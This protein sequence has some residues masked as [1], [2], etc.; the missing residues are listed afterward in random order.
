MT[1]WSLLES[2]IFVI[3][4]I[5]QISYLYDLWW[6]FLIW[7]LTLLSGYP[8]LIFTSLRFYNLLQYHRQIKNSKAYELEPETL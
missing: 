1:I 2:L 3:W 6:L 4:F 7:F 8:F 5:V